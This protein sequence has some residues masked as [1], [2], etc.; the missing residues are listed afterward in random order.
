MDTTSLLRYIAAALLGIA[1]ALGTL[2][3]MKMS[4]KFFNWAKRKMSK[5]DRE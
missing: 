4:D 3:L 1:A 5:S 2:Y